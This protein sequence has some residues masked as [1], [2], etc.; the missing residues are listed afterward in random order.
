MPDEPGPDEDDPVLEEL[1]ERLSIDDASLERLFLDEAERRFRPGELL[2]RGGTAEVRA[3]FDTRLRRHVAVKT[4]IREPRRRTVMRFLQEAQVSG[5][6]E[7]PNIVPVHDLAVGPDGRLQITMKRVQGRSLENLLGTGSAGSLVERLD[8]F[9]KVCDAIALAHSRGVIHRDLKPAN[10]MVGEFGEVLVLDWGLAKVLDGREEPDGDPTVSTEQSLHDGRLTRDDVVLGT[11]AYMPP[12]Q[13]AGR[14]DEVDPRADVYS[15]GALLYALLAGRA[16][17]DGQAMQILYE[18][19]Q[20]RLVPPS[21]R[22]SGHVPPELEAIVLR[23]MAHDPADRYATVE[24]LRGDVQAWI[25]GRPVSVYRY[26]AAERVARWV[27]QRRRV[28]MPVG[29]TAGAA[30]LILIA[31]GAASLIRVTRARDDAVAAQRAADLRYADGQISL[32]SVFIEHGQVEDARQ[33]IEAARGL[34]ELYG[35]S[36]LPA[37]ITEAHL[38]NRYPPPFLTWEDTRARDESDLWQSEGS[39]RLSMWNEDGS[40]TYHAFPTGEQTA[41]YE[42]TPRD[43]Q[44]LGV[45]D[46]R[47]LCAVLEDDRIR[48]TELETGA[49]VAVLA[50]ETRLVTDLRLSA[51]SR[52]VVARTGR[53]IHVWD[54]DAETPVGPPIR[55]DPAEPEVALLSVSADATLVAG[56]ART[57]VLRKPEAVVIWDSRAGTEV[58][59][60]PGTDVAA[61]HP[62]GRW[63]AWATPAGLALG[64]VASGET[65]WSEPAIQFTEVRFTPDGERLLAYSPRGV[66]RWYAVPGGELLGQR[67]LP[68]SPYST[69]RNGD[70]VATRHGDQMRFWVLRDGTPG[71]TLAVDELGVNSLAL[72]PDGVLLLTGSWDGVVRLWETATGALLRELPAS[73]EGTRDVQFSPDATRALSADRDGVV[74]LWDLT[75]GERLREIDGDDGIPMGVRFV[76]GDEAIVAYETGAIVRWDLDDGR[77]RLRYPGADGIVWDIE[78]LP[79]GH[80]LLSGGRVVQNPTAMIWDLETGEQ[81]WRDADQGEAFGVD[82]AP[83]G[84][85][86]AAALW[87]E[88]VMTWRGEQRTPARLADAGSAV[89]DVAYSPDGRVLAAGTYDGR[90]ILYDAASGEELC[91]LDLHD[92]EILDLVYTPDGVL[93]SADQKGRVVQFDQALPDKLARTALTIRGDEDPATRA[94]RLVQLARGT[95]L[96]QDWHHTAEFLEQARAAGGAIPHLD[97]ARALWASGRRDEARAALRQAREDGEALPGTIQVWLAAAG[98]GG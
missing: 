19:S 57:G 77:E 10:V 66:L 54:L 87:T 80:Q 9:R 16:P 68:S 45:R 11:P 25:E 94:D 69:T 51:D 89:M 98:E 49:P 4:L 32:A 83:D 55:F 23:A 74:R 29:A 76:S 8:I 6:L 65:Q 86:F 82:V 48:V 64:E 95:A 28:L 17:Y 97:L 36:T 61:L 91:A 72:S 62:S 88:A 56:S 24:A 44:F 40:I 22:A 81:A 12:E 84:S 78:L 3:V 75:R 46:D 59:R 34:Y 50:Q 53:E 35:A 63:L 33:K 37:D 20:D 90:V 47:A 38:V 58:A 13:A 2:G 14:G 60:F 42:R 1:F 21:R 30:L 41:R 93:I 27:R 70:L 73:P 85:Q 67:P 31:V 18:L 39:M 43:L 92:E 96:R 79:G 7:H 15:L 26:S 5:Q 71:H 52:R